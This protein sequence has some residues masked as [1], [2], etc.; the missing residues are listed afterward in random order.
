MFRLVKGPKGRLDLFAGLRYQI[1]SSSLEK[2]EQL[3]STPSQGSV[4]LV[5]LPQ[6]LGIQEISMLHPVL[7]FHSIA[8]MTKLD[9]GVAGLIKNGDG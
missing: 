6:V 3:K 8:S 9:L 5:G 1:L 4:Y 2:A 7:W